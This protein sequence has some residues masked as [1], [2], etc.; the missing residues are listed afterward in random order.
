M[1]KLL[2]LLYEGDDA[3]ITQ[4]FGNK[5]ILNGVDVY[6]QWGLKGHN[7]LDFGI[8]NG[9]TL[10]S[11]IDG[12]VIEAQFDAGGYGN[13]IKIENDDCGALYAHLEAFGVAVG[14]NVKAGQVIGKSDNT[15]YSTGAHLH[16]AVFP[17]PRDRT[18][19]YGGFIDPLNPALV[20][21]VDDLVT[22]SMEEEI[23]A[24]KAK[25]ANQQIL[26]DTY[27]KQVKELQKAD[28]LEKDALR[29]IV[30][31]LNKVIG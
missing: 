16:F 31:S 18:N 11:C 29:K 19:G 1:I 21:W 23:V 14:E 30:K 12:R 17:I 25:V 5:L 6:A 2:N 4:R 8:P 20:E 3:P 10:Y 13:Y 9:T 24:L 28:L 27:E 26:L 22:P 15:G 7:G